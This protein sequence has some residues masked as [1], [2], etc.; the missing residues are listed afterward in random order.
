[1]KLKECRGRWQAEELGELQHNLAAASQKMNLSPM[2]DSVFGRTAEG[3]VDYRGATFSVPVRYLRVFGV[4]FSAAV[5]KD[6][7]SISECEVDSCVLDGVDMRGVFVR[8]NFN[9]CSFVGAKLASARIG[10]IFRRCNFSGA[11]MAKSVATDCRFER[12]VFTGANLANIL[13]TNCVFEECVFEGVGALS[14]SVAGSRFSGGISQA[15]L[16]RCV[17]DHVRMD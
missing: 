16:E 13:Y 3:L 15:L 8:R 14:G 7:A 5:F 10:S 17:T 6:G 11:G 9:E 4:D 1:M 12:C 2:P